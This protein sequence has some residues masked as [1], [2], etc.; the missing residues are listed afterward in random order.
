ME[1]LQT[2][3]AIFHELGDKEQ[4]ARILNRIG[5][6]YLSLGKFA[7]MLGSLQSFLTKAEEEFEE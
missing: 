6:F 2:A 5:E 7:E 3:F 4:E 1:N